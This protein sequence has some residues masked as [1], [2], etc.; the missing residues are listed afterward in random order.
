V[1]R[2]GH[3]PRWAAEPE[4]IIRIRNK[5]I[6]DFQ[7]HTFPK[8]ILRKIIYTIAFTLYIMSFGIV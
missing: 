5:Y 7:A 4:K 1:V 3:S 8:S 6:G 2:G